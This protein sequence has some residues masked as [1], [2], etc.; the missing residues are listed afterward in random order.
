[1]GGSGEGDPVTVG[2]VTVKEPGQGGRAEGQQ[3]LL[4]LAPHA[5]EAPLAP[6]QALHR[7]ARR[8]WKKP[9]IS[10]VESQDSCLQI[11][12]KHPGGPG[13]ARLCGD[14]EGPG[15]GRLSHGNTGPGP[16]RSAARQPL[17]FWRAACS[18]RPC[19]GH[20]CDTSRS[21]L[22]AAAAPRFPPLLLTPR[23]CYRAGLLGQ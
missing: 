17:A 23:P 20:S 21:Q 11:L 7:P 9:I 19:R 10:L 14:L 12:R 13:P 15:P 6:C 4:A 3:A 18:R 8:A 16:A 22:P 5:S 1:M 2:L